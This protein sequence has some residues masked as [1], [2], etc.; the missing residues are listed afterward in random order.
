MYKNLGSLLLDNFC[1]DVPHRA[2]S[3]SIKLYFICQVMLKNFGYRVKKNMFVKLG[4]F[5]GF[6]D[7]PDDCPGDV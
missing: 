7:F 6:D 1:E 3:A 5:L 4:Y 2:L